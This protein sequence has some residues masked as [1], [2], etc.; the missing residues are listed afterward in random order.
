MRYIEQNCFALQM[1]LGRRFPPDQMFTFHYPLHY[2]R[3]AN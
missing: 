1:H 2:D 3:Y